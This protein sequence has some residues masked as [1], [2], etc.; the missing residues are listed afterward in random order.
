MKD[1]VWFTKL[2]WAYIPITWQG[3]LVIF[4]SAFA[5]LLGSFAI[6]IIGKSAKYGLD[7]AYIVWFLLVW[8]TAM[9]IAR[10]HS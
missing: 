5:I 3:I 9:I 7:I 8:V 2:A 6:Y 10:R 1:R 4:L